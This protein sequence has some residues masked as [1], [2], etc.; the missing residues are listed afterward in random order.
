MTYCIF[1]LIP[2]LIIFFI[3]IEDMMPSFDKIIAIRILEIFL[4]EESQPILAN[5]SMV[6]Y[7]SD[8]S[9]T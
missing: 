7:N 4:R 8:C 9:H 2:I 6:Y 3:I 5:Q 1:S